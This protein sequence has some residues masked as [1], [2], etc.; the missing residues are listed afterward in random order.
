MKKTAIKTINILGSTGSIG[1][2]TLEVVRRNPK[3]FKIRGLAAGR[4]MEVLLEQIRTVEPHAVYVRDLSDAR[5]LQSLCGPSTRIFSGEDGV[6]QLEEECGADILVAGMNG[7]GGLPAVLNALK[8]GKRVALANKEILVAAGNLVMRALKKNTLA[9]LIPVDSEHSA[10]FQCLQAESTGAINR[11][12]TLEKIILTGS[13]GPLREMDTEKFGHVSKEV[14][15]NHPKWKMGKKISVDS[16]TLMNKGLEIIEASWL[17]D[18]AIEKIKVLIHPEAVIH[19]MVEFCDG[20]V[21]AQLGV[22][23]MKLPIQYALS[24]PDRLNVDPSLR[25]DLAKI[26]NLNFFLPDTRKFPCLGLAYEAGKRSGSA[27]CVLSA[28]DEVAVEAYLQDKIRFV[29]IP[30]IIEKILTHH[31]PISD[32]GLEQIRSA[33]DW[34]TEETR[35]LCRL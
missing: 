1:I 7:T 10:I 18:T 31:H 2:N 5:R 28:A 16:A 8:K 24:F 6:S 30:G 13:G 11:A 17:F 29:E 33:H 22:T 32:P 12:R 35:R 20:S 3:N 15:V 25:L 9:S 26:G 23:D 27:P 4:N 19:S 34:A 21:M 14:V